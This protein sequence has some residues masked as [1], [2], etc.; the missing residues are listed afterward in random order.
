MSDRPEL[1]ADIEKTLRRYLDIQKEEARLRE[2]KTALQDTLARHVGLSAS[3]RYWLTSV[4][5]QELKIRCQE[6]TAVEY[7]EPVLRERLGD[8]FGTILSPDLR[9]LRQHLAELSSVLTPH[10]DRIGSPD[11]DRVKAAI[12]QG[13]VK[14]EEFVGAFKKTSRR[15]VAVSRVRPGAS[16]PAEGDDREAG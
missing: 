10:L 7:D 5:G 8:R 4:D 6:T 14:K 3:P 16:L 2:E 15:M 13:L 9:K 12:Q 1:T 11:P